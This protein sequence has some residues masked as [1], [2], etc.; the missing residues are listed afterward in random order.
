MHFAIYM[1]PDGAHVFVPEC[2]QASIEAEALHGPLKFL[3][4]LDWCEEPL[5]AMWKTIMTEIDDHSFA[6]FQ[7]AVAKYLVEAK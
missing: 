2:M 5:P 7:D 3:K 4:F 6:V 1:R